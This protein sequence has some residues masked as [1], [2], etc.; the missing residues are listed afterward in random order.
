MVKFKIAESE[1]GTNY[2]SSSTLFFRSFELKSLKHVQYGV[3]EV[4]ITKRSS[5][6]NRKFTSEISNSLRTEKLSSPKLVGVSATNNAG[7]IEK[8]A[9]QTMR[10]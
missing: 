4:Q 7:D 9:F 2:K 5:K 8:S 3:K 6:D 1:D 10:Y